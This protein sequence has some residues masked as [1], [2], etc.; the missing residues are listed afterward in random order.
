ML[1][2]AQTLHDLLTTHH[3]PPQFVIDQFLTQGGM[4]LLAGNPKVGK[5]TLVGNLILAVARGGVF[6]GRECTQ[7]TVLYLA[8]E[9]QPV[10]VADRFRKLRADKEP[11]VVRAGPIPKDS[12]LETLRHDIAKFEPALAVLDPLFDALDVADSNAYASVNTAMKQV[13]AVARDTGCHILT[14]HHTNKGDNRG[15]LSILGSQALAGATDCNIF[16]TSKWGGGRLFETNQ[17]IGTPFELSTLTYNTATHEIDIEVDVKDQRLQ[18]LEVELLQALPPSGAI[19]STDWR[20]SVK[21][22]N[23]E[24]ATVMLHLEACGKVIRSMEGRTTLW[25]R[26]S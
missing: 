8:M 13:L 3:K 23:T 18:E 15:G 22:R 5:S 17:R 25:A 21:G 12:V 1:P 16:L 11:V 4:S 24:K 7:S 10:G 9:E 26:H 6:L 20:N 19:S 2:P 14:V